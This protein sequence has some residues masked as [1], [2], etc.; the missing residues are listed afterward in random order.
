[1]TPQTSIST[2]LRII[3]QTEG[4]RSFFKG[5]SAAV[6]RIAPYSAIH[7][8]TFDTLR[9]TFHT[10]LTSASA[11][12]TPSHSSPWVYRAADLV[13]GSGAGC[14]AVLITYPLDLVRTR[15]A[16]IREPPPPSQH[17]VMQPGIPLRDLVEGRDLAGDKQPRRPKTMTGLLKIVVVRDGCRGLFQGLGPTLTGIVPYAG[18]KFLVYEGLK[19]ELGEGYGAKHWVHLLTYG[20]VAGLVAQTATY[21]LDVVR[22]RMQV[23]HSTAGTRQSRWAPGHATTASAAIPP[24]DRLLRSTWHGLRTIYRYHGGLPALLSGIAVNYIKVVPSSAVGFVMYDTVKDML[25]VGRRE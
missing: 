2:A 4:L 18:L 6:A 20:A 1:M 11:S 15:L 3:Y 10:H 8:A 17:H 5:N 7:F 13:A 12:G 22:R 25:G 16:Y 21:P 14:A 23:Q 24:Q 9:R 19:R